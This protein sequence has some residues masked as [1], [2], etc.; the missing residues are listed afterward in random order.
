MKIEIKYTGNILNLPSRVADLAPTVSKEDL[1]TIIC[2]FGYNEYFSSFENA[3]PLIAEKLTIS[4]EDVKSSLAFWAKAGVISVDG[5]GEFESKM[6]T[7]TASN[8]MPSYTG[9]QIEAYVAKNKRIGELFKECQSLLGKSF[10]KHDYDNVINLKEYYKFSSAYI[11]LLLAHCVD[12]GKTNW[13]Y[14]RKLANEF[15]DNGIDTY[16]KLETHFADRKNEMS[17]EF[18]I[19]KLFGIGEREFIKT[20]RAVFEKWI[21]N[22]YE[23]ELIQLAY[24]ITIEKTGKSSPRYANKI[25]ENWIS[26]GI[27]TANDAREAQEKYK[28]KQKQETFDADDFFEAALKRSYSDMEDDD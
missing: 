7:D 21:E 24:E 16:K 18:K 11:L 28:S 1:Q 9:A 5:L 27:N 17:L 15:Y 19:R 23:F 14:V 2:L 12:I 4:C 25:L 8:G 10:N 22:K 6:I 20:E 26:S 13:A 3:I